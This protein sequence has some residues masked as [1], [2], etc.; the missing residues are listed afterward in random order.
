LRSFPFDSSA[1]ET[2]AHSRRELALDERSHPRL[3]GGVLRRNVNPQGAVD[4][5]RDANVNEPRAG[6][7]RIR[8]LAFWGES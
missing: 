2:V 5:L 7:S 4:D 6:L 1:D 3:N 8:V